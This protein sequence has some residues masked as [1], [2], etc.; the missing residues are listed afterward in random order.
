MEVVDYECP[1]SLIKEEEPDTHA[2]DLRCPGHPS[3]FLPF[4]GFILLFYNLSNV[5]LL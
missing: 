3:S 5:I 1:P 2:L 4:G